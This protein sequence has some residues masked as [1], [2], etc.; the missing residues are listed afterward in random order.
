MSTGRSFATFTLTLYDMRNDRAYDLKA[1]MMSMKA[2][3]PSTEDATLFSRFLLF[4]ISSGVI[5]VPSLR[6]VRYISIG[7]RAHV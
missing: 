1:S 2:V 6:S 7:P 3:Q 5:A 4:E